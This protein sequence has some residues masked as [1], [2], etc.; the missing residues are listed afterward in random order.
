MVFCGVF[1]KEMCIQNPA[2]HAPRGERERGRER[3]EGLKTVLPKRGISAIRGSPPNPEGSCKDP[4]PPQVVFQD[5]SPVPVFAEVL[6]LELLV[7]ASVPT[8]QRRLRS[9][10]QP[11]IGLG[12]VL[13]KI[14][15]HHL[16]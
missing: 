12:E 3:G 9:L 1:K 15:D 5:D 4:S 11:G 8:C 14:L 6:S 16:F 13:K 10:F 2:C 7:L